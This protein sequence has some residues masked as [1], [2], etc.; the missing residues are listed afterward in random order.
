[1]KLRCSTPDAYG[2]LYME[3]Q[4]GEYADSVPMEDDML[5]VD[6]DAHGRTL[7]VEILDVAGFLERVRC[8]GGAF[9][10]PDHVDL[11]ASPEP[12]AGSHGGD[13]LIDSEHP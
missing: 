13:T 6:V 5:V 3:L 12:A 4:A 10:I 9:E 7:G 2:V 8:H 11:A 1:M